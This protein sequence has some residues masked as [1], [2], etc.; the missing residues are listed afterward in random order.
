ML[1]LIVSNC[2]ESRL[3]KRD[4][5][6]GSTVSGCGQGLTT[7]CSVASV[8]SPIVREHAEDHHSIPQPLFMTLM[9]CFGCGVHFP[10]S[11]CPFNAA[12]ASPSPDL[13]LM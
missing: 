3:V 8:I 13:Y 10:I 5:D 4:L 2:M 1:G 7:H 6:A 12:A 9:K 11:C